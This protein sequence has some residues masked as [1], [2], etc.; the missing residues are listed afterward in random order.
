M[1]LYQREYRVRRMSGTF[2]SHNKVRYGRP[3][4]SDL[5]ARRVGTE[6]PAVGTVMRSLAVM[7][8]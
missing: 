6:F 3:L 7:S 2:V 1:R 8:A 5:V 4:A